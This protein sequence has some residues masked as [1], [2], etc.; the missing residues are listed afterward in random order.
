MV[1]LTAKDAWRQLHSESQTTVTY[2]GFM[3]WVHKLSIDP[4]LGIDGDAL[5]VL[6]NYAKV[7]AKAASTRTHQN[8]QAKLAVL[9]A[10]AKRQTWK[11]SELVQ[12][13]EVYGALSRGTLYRRATTVLGRDFS[14]TAEY[15]REQARLLIFGA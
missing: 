2:N 3:K 15:S 13:V 4:S 10:I 11:G 6:R 8:G 5:K 7:R 1:C 12:M 9:K 14:A